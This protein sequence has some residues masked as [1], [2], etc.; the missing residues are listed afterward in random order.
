MNA[1]A[2]LKLVGTAAV[3]NHHVPLGKVIA[4]VIL[5][6][7]ETLSVNGTTARPII[8][9]LEVIGLPVPIAVLVSSIII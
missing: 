8:Q 5:N 9:V 6:V 4:T 1:M 2:I 3:K 7:T